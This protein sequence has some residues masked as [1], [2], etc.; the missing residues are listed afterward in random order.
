MSKPH[1][2]TEADIDLIRH[3]YTSREMP[4]C[5]L[6]KTI[7]ISYASLKWKAAC[8]GLSRPNVNG[9]FRFTPEQDETMMQMAGQYNVSSIA[10]KVG[11]SPQAVR[12]R[13]QYLG[14]SYEISNRDEWYT[15]D[16]VAKI[17]GMGQDTVRRLIHDKVLKS[18]PFHKDNPAT[19]HGEA[20]QISKAALRDYI[21]RHPHQLR[22]RKI[23]MIN[24]VEILAGV[25]A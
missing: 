20:W 18:Q 22:G 23:D 2:Y 17:L 3:Y 10:T 24:L 15:C 1:A 4:L 14:I 6:A 19:M 25:I 13:M 16:D 5:K 7:G 11:R 12:D 9:A 8:L 21:R